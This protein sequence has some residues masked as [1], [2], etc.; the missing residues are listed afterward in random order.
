MEFLILLGIGLTIGG[1]AMAADDDD[2]G[3]SEPDATE[4]P[5][6]E[7]PVSTITTSDAADDL[8]AT[9]QD[10]TIFARGGDDI[11]EGRGGDDRLFGMD[12]TDILV[13]GTG[14]DFVR[15][16]AGDDYLID[17]DGSDTLHGDAGDDRI[18]STSGI[19]GEGIVGF[20]RGVAD[21]SITD[22]SGLSGFVNPDTDLDGDAD[23]V[24]AGY[25]DDTVIAGDGDTISL[26]EGRDTLVVGDWVASNDDPVIVTDFDPAEDLL[27]Y[28]CNGDGLPPRL[29]VQTVGDGSGDEGQ[30]S[31]LLFADNVFVA[32]IQ[33]AGGLL[34]VSDVSIDDR[35]SGGSF[36]S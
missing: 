23:S 26:G 18:I 34:T 11:V 21:G 32:R 5:H 6:T 9:D 12:G 20:S 15:G 29:S 25:G 17:N 36:F 16:G 7:E 4:P 10:E 30:G 2:D 14:D 33:G 1:V 35:S 24:S 3:A 8:T 13:G 22:I 31:A 27:V 19:D 28:S